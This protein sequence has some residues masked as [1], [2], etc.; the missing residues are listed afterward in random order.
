MTH[1]LLH[2]TP[3]RL[4]IAALALAATP[5]NVAPPVGAAPAAPAGHSEVSARAAALR[6]F[7]AARVG[8]PSEPETFMLTIQTATTISKI[9]ATRDFHVTG[10]TCIEGHNYVAHDVCSVEVTFTPQ[11]AGHR[12]GMLKVEH[13]ASPQPLIVP[14]G[15]EGYAPII[16]FVPSEIMPVASTLSGGTGVLKNAQGLAVDSGNSLYIADTG[17]NLIRY[18]DSNGVLT[19]FA[20]GGTGTSGVPTS[21]A[22]SSPAAVAID[23]IGDAW[24]ADSGNDVVR[25]AGPN[26]GNEIYDFIGGGTDTDTCTP[27]SPCSGT[28]E[29]TNAPENLAFDSA[30]N[31]FL[32]YVEGSGGELAESPQA[33][34][35][36]QFYYLNSFLADESTSYALAVDN[37]DNLYYAD[38]IPA[39]DEGNNTPVCRIY[40]QN[41]TWSTAEGSGSYIWSLAGTNNCGYS[42]DGGPA[43]GAEISSTISTLVFDLGGNFYF[44]DT[45]NNRIRRID[46]ETGVI[47][48]VAGNGAAAYGGDYGS[49]TSAATWAPTGLA[50]DSLGNMYVITK[51]NSS[52]N[53]LVRTFG[54]IGLASYPSQTVGT[55]SAARTVMIS[56]TGNDELDFTHEGFVT[57]NAGDFAMDP[58]TT[59]CNFTQPLYSGQNCLVGIIFTPTA[60]GTRTSQLRLLSNTASGTNYITVTGTAA[61]PTTAVISPTSLTYA[62]QSVNSAS[63]AQTVKLSNTGSASITINS[64]AF[65]GTD[66]TDFSQTNN[67]GTTVAAAG[68]CTFS[69]VF[70]PAASGTRTA[71]L[72][73]TT[74]GGTVAVSITGTGVT[75]TVKPKVSLAPKVNPAKTG[76]ALTFNSLVAASG[77]KEPTGKVELKEGSKVLSEESLTKGAVTFKL[78]KLSAG[79]HNLMAYY[80]GDSTHEPANSPAVKQVV[81]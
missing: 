51:Q 32:Y 43:T 63:A 36:G 66:H 5:F 53:A 65:T 72:S 23:V 42:G 14:T 55:S 19:T 12:G 80:L 77:T 49:S 37:S 34:Y 60:S 78:A 15:G 74:T 50:P 71:S 10:G 76:Q 13:S 47:R 2:S 9:S 44:S 48:T 21:V 4:A 52:G 6:T 25:S 33:N 54:A 41:P 20:G 57:G 64:Y 75:P 16:S 62:S 56:N 38:T 22:L 81:K 40:G 11:G 67:C 29:V 18:Q 69:I 3:A 28:A 27:S 30:G 39:A 31:L 70:K 68:S 58:N 59:S 35:L 45:G 1:L 24:I 26:E 79:T 46:A 7:A 73:V 17:N 61:A 8:V